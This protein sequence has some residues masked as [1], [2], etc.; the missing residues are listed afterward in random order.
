MAAEDDPRRADAVFG[1]ELPF[2]RDFSPSHPFRAAAAPGTEREDD[3]P[4]ATVFL[5]LLA[6]A[7]PPPAAAAAT[8]AE[9]AAAAAAE[10][11]GPDTELRVRGVLDLVPGLPVPDM[12]DTVKELGRASRECAGEGGAAPEEMDADI[13]PRG[14]ERGVTPGTNRVR[15]R[16]RPAWNG[17]RTRTKG[18]GTCVREAW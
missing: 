7:V 3:G 1:P 10:P 5:L 2:P 12:P 16:V 14:V 6:G 13:D 15:V 11:T 8:A 9:A 4:G 17:G 18:R